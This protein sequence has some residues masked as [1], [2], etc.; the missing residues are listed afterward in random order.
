MNAS[1]RLQSYSGQSS[2]FA[3]KRR[4]RN[5]VGWTAG[6]LAVISWV[7]ILSRLTFLSTFA[8]D[9]VN[10]YSA[11]QDLVPAV[12]SVAYRELQGAYLGIFSKANSIIYPKRA[13]T[14]AVA[15]SSPRIDTV[16]IAREGRHGL[17]ISISEK[18]AAGIV[19]PELPSF[20]EDA[21]LIRGQGC[22]FADDDGLVFE[23]VP[24]SDTGT[25]NRYY[26]PTLPTDDTI[27]GRHA[28]STTRFKTLQIFIETAKGAGIVPEALLIKD[29][30]EYELYIDNPLPGKTSTSSDHRGPIVIYMND[31]VSLATELDNLVLFWSTMMDKA[32]AKGTPLELSEIKLQYP[33][34]VY[35][36]EVKL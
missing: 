8:I 20:D 36:T 16:S 6:V 25:Y 5:I 32:R 19:C 15:S 24:E 26:A 27:I 31:R 12:Q 10:V 9:T 4:R 30:G 18:P 23:R 29:G 35:Y 28:T 7:F 11:R 2:S 14:A 21:A 33:P 3:R 34:N 13:I 17:N 22:Y 1:S